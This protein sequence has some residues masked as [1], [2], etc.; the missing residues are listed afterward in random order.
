MR[1]K[2]ITLLAIALM[3]VAAPTFAE[4]QNVEV[5]GSLQIRGNFY[6]AESFGADSAGPNDAY[7]EMRATV[8]V[9]ADFTDDVTVFIELDTYDQFGGDFDSTGSTPYS[10]NNALN[11]NRDGYT[12]G[13]AAN[14]YQAYVE[15]RETLG[16][17]VTLRIGRQ[18]IQLGSEW[19]VGNENTGAQFMHLAFDGTTARYDFDGGSVTAIAVKVTDAD[20]TLLLAQTVPLDEDGDTDLYAL[21]G[22]YTGIEDITI[23]AYWILTRSAAVGTTASDINTFGARV[24]GTWNAFD[25]EVEAA[26]QD[27]DDESMTPSADYSASAIN[28]EVGYSFDV[29]YQPRVFAGIAWFEGDSD[30]HAFDRVFSDWEY[31]EFLDNGQLSNVVIYRLGASAQ[32]SENIEVS[33]VAS[34]F[35]VEDD[36]STGGATNTVNGDDELGWEIDVYAVYDYSEDLQFEIGYAHFFADDA[37]DSDSVTMLANN[38]AILNNGN[39]ILAAGQGDDADY[40]YA[41]TSISF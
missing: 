28:A 12:T 32:A 31:S 6:S 39:S 25:F 15:T 9:T 5:G 2:L 4:L 37:L 10:A 11:A 17:P 40:I 23:D 36:S 8:N 35:Q 3:A 29:N 24:A 20:N 19:L 26:T 14:F 18:E 1:F 22:T 38:P 33:A 7:T 13:S 41:Q 27:G 21:Y 34:Y 16:Y 30:D